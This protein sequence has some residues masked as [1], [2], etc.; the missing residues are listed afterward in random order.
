MILSRCC[1]AMPERQETG[2]RCLACG[3]PCRVRWAAPVTMR[4]EDDWKD[5]QLARVAT[6]GGEIV[7]RIEPAEVIRS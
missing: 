7:G 6:N 4:R 2:Y 1:H 5:A 3:C